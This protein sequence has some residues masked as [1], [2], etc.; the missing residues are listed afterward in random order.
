MEL[1]SKTQLVQED[2]SEKG[3]H[4]PLVLPTVQ[5][6]CLIA[7]ATLVL[8]VS[9]LNQFLMQESQPVTVFKNAVMGKGFN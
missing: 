3:S 7:H 8:M 6:V 4:V 1:V 2:F 5:I 9:N